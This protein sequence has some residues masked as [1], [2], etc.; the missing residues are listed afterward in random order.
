MF[1]HWCSFFLMFVHVFYFFFFLLFIFVYFLVFSSSVECFCTSSF[2]FFFFFQSRPSRRQNPQKIVHKFLLQKRRFPF[3]KIWFLSLGGRGGF[4]VAHLRVTSL[5]CLSFFFLAIFLS[6]YQKCLF[7][8][9]F[10]V[11]LSSMCCCWHLNQSLTVDVSA[12]GAPWRCGVLTTQG[13]I[14]WIGLGRQLG[15]EHDSTLQSGVEAP[16][17]FKRSLARLY[18]CCWWWFSLWWWRKM[19]SK[20]EASVGGRSGWGWGWWW[21]WGWER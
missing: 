4:G 19:E 16:R 21:W 20:E 18:Y 17:L 13:G 7:L 11:F 10:L 5:A 12:V 6:S 14:A 9:S 15:R 8:F 1:P 3:V 2:S